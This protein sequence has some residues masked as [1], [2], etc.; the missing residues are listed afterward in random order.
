[1]ITSKGSNPG[2]HQVLSWSTISQTGGCATL[3]GTNNLFNFLCKPSISSS[4]GASF[5][6]GLHKTF[7]CFKKWNSKEEENKTTKKAKQ[8][9]K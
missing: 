6:P 2:L 1:M 3:S 7:F 9:E 4:P 5:P 8:R